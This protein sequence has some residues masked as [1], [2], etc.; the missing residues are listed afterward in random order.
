MSSF[1]GQCRQGKVQARVSPVQALQV[2][3]SYG[4]YD[5]AARMIMMVIMESFDYGPV[6]EDMVLTLHKSPEH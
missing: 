1:R 4:L 6:Y 5:C 3:R 2:G